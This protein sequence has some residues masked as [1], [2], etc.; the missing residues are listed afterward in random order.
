MR[1]QRGQS[2]NP[3]G[4]P[5]ILRDV[6]EAARQHTAEAIATLVTIAEDEKAPA[7]ARV[8]AATVLL[9]R[10]WGRPRQDMRV[11]RVDDFDDMS[12][13][14]LRALVAQRHR[15][16]MEAEARSREGSNRKPARVSRKLH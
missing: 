9:D 14:E 12:D 13:D 8:S 11:E 2:G 5:K 10:G 4:R 16:L 1:W 7:A 15:E 3:G 6:Q